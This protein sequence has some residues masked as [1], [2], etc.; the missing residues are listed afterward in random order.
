MNHFPGKQLQ[1]LILAQPPPSVNLEQY[2]AVSVFSTCNEGQRNA[3]SCR[4]IRC[5]HRALRKRML[6]RREAGAL[7]ALGPANRGC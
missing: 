4:E 1:N 5:F 7:S 6:K 3:P 2:G